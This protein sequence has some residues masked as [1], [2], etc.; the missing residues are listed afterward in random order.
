M[1]KTLNELEREATEFRY[2]FGTAFYTQEAEDSYDVDWVYANGLRAYSDGKGI[3]FTGINTIWDVKTSEFDV[4]FLINSNNVIANWAHDDLEKWAKNGFKG[5]KK[6]I[7]KG[8]KGSKWY[9]AI[10]PRED[11]FHFSRG[12]ATCEDCIQDTILYK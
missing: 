7:V 8:N 3:H 4:V 2:K 5:V 10:T 6:L 12:Y 9:H 1:R 11:E